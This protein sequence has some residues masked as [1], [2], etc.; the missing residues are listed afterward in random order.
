MFPETA[1]VY[2]CYQDCTLLIRRDARVPNLPTFWESPGG[3][4]DILAEFPKDLDEI[5]REAAR[6]LREETD[7]AVDAQELELLPAPHTTSAHCS[8]LLDLERLPQVRLSFEHDAYTWWNSSRPIP[9]K[10]R[11]QVSRFLKER[12]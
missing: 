1:S 9:T 5:K 8:F 10:I 3:H 4:L 7:I 11:W 12:S 2:V 6:E